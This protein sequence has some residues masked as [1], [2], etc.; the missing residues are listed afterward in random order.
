MTS[1]TENRRVQRAAPP[2]RK[3]K[4]FR[5]HFAK[6]GSPPG[7]LHIPEGSPKPRIR[8][9]A[10]GPEALDE[11]DIATPEEARAAVQ[12]GRVAWIDVSGLGDE[13]ILRGLGDA[14]EIH[15][16]ALSDV[17]HTGQRPKADSYGEALFCVARMATHESD[18]EFTWEQMSLWLGDGFVLTFQ[19]TPGDCLESLRDRIR[20]GQKA[21]R[22]SGADYL[23]T[24]LLDGI[25]DG[26]FPVL[27]AY[28][29]K[30]ESIEARVIER[31]D[32]RV[33]GEV[34][35]M[36]R[37]LM[38]FR[39]AAWPLRDVLNHLLRDGHVRLSPAVAPYLRDAA[40]HVAQ[41]VDVIE[42]YRELAGSFVDVYLSSVSNRTNE[43]MRVLTVISTIFIPLTFLAGVYGM[44]F[45]R[46]EPGNMPE[47]G[48]PYGYVGF[49]AI[50]LALGIALLVAFRRL[51]WLGG[52]R[53]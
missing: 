38:T 25:V 36:K 3:K 8:V 48:W 51:G 52:R 15:P 32:P 19:E 27:E 22:G 24:M 42:S 46:A 47:L 53:R 23:A 21:L 6:P 29:E 35:R 49:W 45:D 5:R 33:L 37:D 2:H 26:Y 41:V 43:A 13:A 16:L 50:S 31:P 11:R 18:G 40:D 4:L 17:V 10:Y 28:G 44:N 14:F 12:P 7:T 30:L 34:Y 39:R 1:D 9:M 20:R